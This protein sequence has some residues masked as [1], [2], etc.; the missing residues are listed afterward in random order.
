MLKQQNTVQH[1][2]AE[3][4]TQHTCTGWPKNCIPHGICSI[5]HIDAT[6]EDKMKQ[7]SPKYPQSLSDY[8]RIK[9][10]S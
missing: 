6:V 8:M 3:I 9:I 4:T 2:T 1:T 7:I 10:R 5:H